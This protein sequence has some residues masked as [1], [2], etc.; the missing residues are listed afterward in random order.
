MERDDEIGVELNESPIASRSSTLPRSSRL[1]LPSLDTSQQRQTSKPSRLTPP[2]RASISPS[3]QRHGGVA[4][5]GGDQSSLSSPYSPSPSSPLRHHSPTHQSP[6]QSHKQQQQPVAP[7]SH[8]PYPPSASADFEMSL[9]ASKSQL[10][11]PFSAPGSP[12]RR[13]PKEGNVRVIVR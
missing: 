5:N 3:G 4:L 11:H 8:A 7:S 12:T 1:P 13:K 10:I 2:P 9:N 6:H